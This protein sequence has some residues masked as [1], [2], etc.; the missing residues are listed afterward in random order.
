MNLSLRVSAAGNHCS[1]KESEIFDPSMNRMLA[2]AG[3]SPPVTSTAKACLPVG[4]EPFQF[5]MFFVSLWGW[6]V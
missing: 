1:N 5:L 3:F 2:S 4:R 6:V